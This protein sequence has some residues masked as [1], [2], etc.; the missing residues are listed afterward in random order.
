VITVKLKSEKECKLKYSVLPRKQCRCRE[1]A[2]CQVP[3]LHLPVNDK[4][5]GKY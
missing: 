3:S 5:L 2:K 1:E 4:S